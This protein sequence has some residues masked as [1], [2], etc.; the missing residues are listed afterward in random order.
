MMQRIL[1]GLARLPVTIVATAGPTIDPSALS[2]PDGATIHRHLP[3]HDVMPAASLVVGH[4]GH[5]TTVRA[6][7]H[8][9]PLLILP[10]D[11]RIDQGMVGRA[12]E[13]AGAGLCLPRSSSPDAIRDAASRI[14]T[15]EGFAREAAAAGARIRAANGIC[16]AADAIE[17]LVR[18]RPRGAL[19]G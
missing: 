13:L 17:S 4:G 9:L 7:M 12:V 3:H 16:T 8:G 1:D 15:T 19:A 18:Q 14:L 11:P 10:A 2:V 6:L 5:S